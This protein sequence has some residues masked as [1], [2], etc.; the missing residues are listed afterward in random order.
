MLSVQFVEQERRLARER[1][2]KRQGTAS[3]DIEVLE[4]PYEE[5]ENAEEKDVE[6]IKKLF[7]EQGEVDRLDFRNH[8][9]AII[10]QQGLAD[11][12][13]ASGVSAER[14]ITDSGETYP[15]LDLP[16]P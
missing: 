2:F 11:A 7:R 1:T 10:S 8:I 3:V 5:T 4:F 15:K 12:M 9:P 13:T 14:M 6:R 16:Y